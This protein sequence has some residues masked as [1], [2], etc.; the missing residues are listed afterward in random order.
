MA[1][2]F[3][4]YAREDA[5]KAGCLARSLE[6]VGHGVWWDRQIEGGARFGAAIAAAL[7]AADAIVVLWSSNS[8]DSAWVQDEAAAAR[9][10]K[11]LVPVLVEAVDPPLGFFELA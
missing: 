7:N 4:S 6:A 10:T 8:V 1:S 11:R 5:K 2:L 3:L 9:D